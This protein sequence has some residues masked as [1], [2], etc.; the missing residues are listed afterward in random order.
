MNAN[1]STLGGLV[2]VVAILYGVQS[3]AQEP[4]TSEN[5]RYAE[6]DM[7][8]RVVVPALTRRSND[9]IVVSSGQAAGSLIPVELL[10]HRCDFR[11]TI[12][13][14][15][16]RTI[17]L[18]EFEIREGGGGGFRWHCWESANSYP[19]DFAVFMT[20]NHVPY[21]CIAS[22]DGVRLFRITKSNDSEMERQR[23][24]EA[25][26]QLGEIEALR[27]GYLREAVGKEAFHSQNAL[28]DAVE[29]DR[30]FEAEFKLHV[31]LHGSDPNRKFTFALNGSKWSLVEQ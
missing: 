9:T 10:A 8:K 17:Q 27:I 15:E 30:V 3:V 13:G 20:E 31:T 12:D 21:A 28:Y 22:S 24:L 14:H 23:F 2:M 1:K 11:V 5:V 16:G 4:A 6:V 25:R 19:H 29:V 26:P 18:M 7:I